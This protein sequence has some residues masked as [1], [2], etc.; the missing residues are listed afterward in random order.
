[1]H[2]RILALLLL[3]SCRG[4]PEPATKL[5]LEVQGMTCGSCEQAIQTEV[6][7]LPGVRAVRASH[8]EKRAW[9][10][11]ERGRVTTETIIKTINRLGYRASLPRTAPRN[12]AKE[13]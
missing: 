9:V 3:S 1:M 7:R 12:P 8:R 11:L 10:T 4:S 5:T 13:R 2:V 6:G